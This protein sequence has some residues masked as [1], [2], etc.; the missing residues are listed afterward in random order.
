M[1]ERLSLFLFGRNPGLTMKL[2]IYLLIVGCLFSVGAFAQTSKAIEADL[3]KSLNQINYWDRKTLPD[4]KEVNF[5]LLSK[6]NND[7]ERKLKYYGKIN[8]NVINKVFKD[9]GGFSFG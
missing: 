5:D 1:V 7:L 3:L 2:K 6:A 8:S 9:I 4:N